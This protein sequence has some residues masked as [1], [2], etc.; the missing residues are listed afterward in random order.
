MKVINGHHCDVNVKYIIPEARGVFSEEL[1]TKKCLKLPWIG[2]TLF[3]EVDCS[4]IKC[5]ILLH[6]IRIKD[7]MRLIH[8]KQPYQPLI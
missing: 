7:K 4:Y 3:S 5:S 1:S 8:K 6:K 2:V